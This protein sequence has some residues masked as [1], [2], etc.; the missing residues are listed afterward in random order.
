[1]TKTSPS[2][3]I[4]KRKALRR[5]GTFNM[6][7]R[8][9]EEIAAANGGRRPD[10]YLTFG[11]MSDDVWAAYDSGT[12]LE[13]FDGDGNHACTVPMDWRERTHKALDRAVRDALA[14]LRRTP[15][16]HYWDLYYAVEMKPEGWR[17]HL[18]DEVGSL[19]RLYCAA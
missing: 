17:K 7:L 5:I 18:K 2:D 4:L 12:A 10:M 19:R 15:L 1:M 8:S 11:S 13:V 6:A 9:M 16:D 3:A 14:S